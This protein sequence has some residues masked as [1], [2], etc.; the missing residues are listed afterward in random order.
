MTA[1]VEDKG[2]V[3]RLTEARHKLR[4][5]WGSQEN[6][7][8]AID[9][10]DEAIALIERLTSERDEARAKLVQADSSEAS[11][12][13]KFRPTAEWLPKET[14]PKDGSSFLLA[15]MAG[16]GPTVCEAEFVL[17]GYSARSGGRIKYKCGHMEL[18]SND[19]MGWMP[20]PLAPDGS[21]NFSDESGSD[22]VGL[23]QT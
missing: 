12:N 4:D 1:L 7:F 2:I 8:G 19:I 3:K 14:I 15:Y 6:I 11:S 10:M 13:E 23:K 18:Y 17:D 21:L 22:A 16:R 9:A 5:D 20:L